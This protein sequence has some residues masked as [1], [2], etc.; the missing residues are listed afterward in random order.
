MEDSFEQ[1]VYVSLEKGENWETGKKSRANFELYSDEYLNLTFLNTVLLKYVITTR[2]LG[3]RDTYDGRNFS[4]L[5]PY[6]NRAMEFL[7]EREKEEEKLLSKYM[8]L[9]NEWQMDVS[10]FKMEKNVHRL[11]D[12][13]AKRFCKWY[14]QHTNQEP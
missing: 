14:E 8:N 7:K 5:L 1:T 11:S 3:A 12:Y 9:P 10:R 2:N 13:Q 4:G 6:L